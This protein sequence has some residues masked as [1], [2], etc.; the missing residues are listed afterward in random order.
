MWAHLDEMLRE[1]R[2]LVRGDT[3]DGTAAFYPS[4]VGNL[5]HLF[6][7]AANRRRLGT[8]WSTR[9]RPCSWRSSPLGLILGQRCEQSR[10][11]V[12]DRADPRWYGR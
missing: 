6:D 11:V 10:M 7:D 3:P 9:R 12:L 5:C 1:D 4:A 8:A 2:P